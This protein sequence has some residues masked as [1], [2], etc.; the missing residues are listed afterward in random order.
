MHTQMASPKLSKWPFL[1]GDVLL[2]GLAGFLFIQSKRPLGSWEML[3]CTLCVAV[4]AGCGILPF[5]LEYRVLVKLLVADHL[6]TVTSEIQKL[7]QVADQV[8]GATSR[9]QTVQESADRTAKTAREIVDRMTGEMKEFTEF[10]KNTNEGEK[11]TLR[12]EVDKLRRAEAD[13]LQ[14]LVRMLDHVYAVY[15]AGVRSRQP[16]LVE[17]L[18][19]FQNACRDAAR[20]VGLTP[21]VP[22]AEARFDKER[23]QLADGDAEPGPDAKVGETVATGYTFQGRLL[24][25]ALVRLQNGTEP[26]TFAEQQTNEATEPA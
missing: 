11:S 10:L 26:K 5:I 8:R 1:A 25:P 12:L 18:G 16:S 7:D 24:R 23:H 6:V 3:A 9:W 19:Q 21:F 2:L 17:Q 15:Q 20:R 4:G 13:W 22:D 14:A